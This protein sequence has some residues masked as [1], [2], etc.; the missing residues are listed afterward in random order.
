MERYTMFLDGKNQYRENITP[1]AVYKFNA[2]PIELPTAFSKELGLRIFTSCM[3]TLK[4]LNSQ[5]NL[6]K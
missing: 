4:T 2:T 5:S 3:E 6:K 1:K